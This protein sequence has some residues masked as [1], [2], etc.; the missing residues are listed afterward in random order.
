MVY[1]I[2]VFVLFSI[3]IVYLSWPSLRNPR[4]HGFFRFFAF[5]TLLLLILYNI[6]YWFLNPF[7]PMQI[8][9]WLALAGSLAMAI[10]GFYLLRVIGQ[11]HADI[12]NTTRLVKN[13][14]YGYIRHP[15]YASLLL[16]GVGALLKTPSLVAG[17]MLTALIAFLIATARIEEGENIQRFGEQ[18][19]SYMEETKMFIPFVF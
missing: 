6:D 9:S 11:P 15:L 14:A 8:L 2:I 16:L 10:H 17:G 12:E 3:G 13:G 7:S 4:L 19:K 5:E 1:K 18:Y